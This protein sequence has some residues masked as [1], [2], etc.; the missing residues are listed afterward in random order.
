MMNLELCKF[1]IEKFKK[2]KEDMLRVENEG[3]ILL[4]E[5]P[6]EEIDEF[7]DQV[8]ENRIELISSF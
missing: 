7:A 4:N 2:A 5:A 3:S 8:N 1:E 6:K